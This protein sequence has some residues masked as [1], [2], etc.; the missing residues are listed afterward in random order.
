[1][2]PTY[3]SQ[4]SKGGEFSFND[5]QVS[6]D[7][8]KDEHVSAHIAI[9]SLLER[10]IPAIYLETKPPDQLGFIEAYAQYTGIYGHIRAGLVP[11]GFGSSGLEK[12]HD[13]IWPKPMIFAERIVGER[14]YG[15]SFFTENNGYFTEFTLHNGEVDQQPNDGNLWL[16]TRWG[17]ANE[18]QLQIQVSG[19]AGRTDGVSTALGSTTL[20]GWD[21]TKS[22]AWRFANL[23]VAWRPRY[24]E[25][26]LQA[27]IGQR[28]QNRKTDSVTSH[29]VD[30]IHYFAKNWGFGLRHD[31]FD[32]NTKMSNDRVS[33]ESVML[34]NQSSDATSVLSVVYS[35]V[36]EEKYQRPNDEAWLQWRV[37]PFVK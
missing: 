7:W 15:V 3:F 13:R 1:M 18:R 8:I 5:S 20:A 2:R 31:D 22:A 4:E 24:F 23:A 25:V 10:S 34:L 33:R 27:T 17:W 9:G 28:E 12:N 35:K 37:T 16:T 21:R 14:D 19:Q 29:Q 6:F 32:P 36:L 11:L 30:F 26:Q